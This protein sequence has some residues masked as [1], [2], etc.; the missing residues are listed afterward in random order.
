MKTCFILLLSAFTLLSW[1]DREIANT[2]KIELQENTV[3]TIPAGKKWKMDVSTFRKFSFCENTDCGEE[4]HFFKSVAK[5][6]KAR[7]ATIKGSITLH[8]GIT[9]KTQ[10]SETPII[11]HELMIVEE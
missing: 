11:V 7:S 3:Y 1:T 2:Q 4:M 9:I 6:A 8:E 10:S 5:K